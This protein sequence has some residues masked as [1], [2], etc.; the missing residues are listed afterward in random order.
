[1]AVERCFRANENEKNRSYG[2][3]VLQIENRPFTP[4]VFATNGIVGKECIRFHKRLVET[5]VDKRKAP[6]SIITNNIRTLICFSLLRSTVKCLK[7]SRS[8]KYL[9]TNG[10]DIKIDA[11]I[12]ID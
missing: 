7:C 9:H 1:M 4:L 12:K 6:I 11:L 5:I 2:N 10:I 3:R 8:P